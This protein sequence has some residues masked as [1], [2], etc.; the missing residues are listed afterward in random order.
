MS[1]SIVS[2]SACVCV[3]VLYVR[4]LCLLCVCAVLSVCVYNFGRGEPSEP[5]PTPTGQDP[6]HKIWTML[7]NCGPNRLG[8]WLNQLRPWRAGMLMRLG[9]RTLSL[10][11]PPNTPPNRRHFGARSSNRRPPLHLHDTDAPRYGC[12]T[13]SMCARRRANPTGPNR[14]KGRCLGPGGPI[15]RSQSRQ[16][17]PRSFSSHR[18]PGT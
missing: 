17:P 1:V 4:V 14:P 6:M 11:P 10:H 9:G 8:L 12:T 5:Q 16:P 13:P 15:L 3:C 7:Q 18:R 2:M